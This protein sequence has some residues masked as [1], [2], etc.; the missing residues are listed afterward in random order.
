MSTGNYPNGMTGRD[1][2]YVN[3]DHLADDQIPVSDCCGA[4]IIYGDI[5][6]E[7]KEHCDPLEEGKDS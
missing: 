2:A 7:C 3:G 1:W 6:S 4:E 5:C